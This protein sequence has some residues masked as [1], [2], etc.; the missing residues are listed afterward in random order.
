MNVSTLTPRHIHGSGIYMAFNKIIHHRRSIRLPG[1]DYSQP[2]AYFVTICT[3]Q[4]E[5]LFGEIV[6]GEMRVNEIGMIVK[7]TWDSLERR[8]PFIETDEFIVMPNHIH[9]IVWIHD[10]GAYPCDRPISVGANPAFAPCD[11]VACTLNRTVASNNE[12]Q[13]GCG[14][15]AATGCG[16]ITRIRP[17]GKMAGTRMGS[18]CRV[19]QAFKSIATVEYIRYQRNFNLNEVCPKLWQRNYYEHIIRSD[20][21]LDSVRKYIVENPLKWGDDPEQSGQYIKNAVGAYPC[22]RPAPRPCAVQG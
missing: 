16:A 10:V 13:F 7:N 5:R 1:Y 22:D 19:I 18:I 4:K 12:K 2:N 6:G 14:A 11:E 8:F 17:Y 3:F 15:I 21:E 20:S 9:G